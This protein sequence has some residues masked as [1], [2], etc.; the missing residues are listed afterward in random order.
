MLSLVK[1][2]DSS[3]LMKTAFDSS[4]LIV[5]FVFPGLGNAYKRV[6]L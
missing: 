6:V 2:Q 5:N 4:I 3:V 1:K